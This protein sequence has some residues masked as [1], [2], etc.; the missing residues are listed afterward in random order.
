MAIK[1]KSYHQI[2]Q[3]CVALEYA[4]QKFKSSL[5]VG[6]LVAENYAGHYQGIG[7]VA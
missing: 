2:V 5:C 7:R 6:Q 4:P 3:I 1:I